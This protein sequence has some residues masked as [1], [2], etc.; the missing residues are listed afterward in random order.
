[1]GLAHSPRIV[2]DGLVLLLDAGN[3]KSYPGSGT[4]WSDLSGNGNNGTLTNGPTYSS[5]SIVFDGTD[6]YVSLGTNP[7]GIDQVQVPLTICAWVKADTFGSYDP[8]WAADKLTTSAGL[9]S[10]LRVDSSTVV[11]FT[12]TSS[13]S[14]QFFTGSTL[15]TGTWYFLTV[16]VSG[17]LSSPTIAHYTNGSL[18]SSSTGYSMS[19]SPLSN[20]EFRIGANERTSGE[21]WDGNIPAVLWYNK[22]LSASEIQ[23]N[24]NALRG[25][26]GI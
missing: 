8:I 17:S 22:A 14:F 7:T 2:N 16:V 21:R 3:T 19:S 12:S 15:S 24:F 23:Q 5:G 13:G 26:F 25:R 1:M 20:V 10:M 9:Y 6:D 4:T 18:V 11:Y